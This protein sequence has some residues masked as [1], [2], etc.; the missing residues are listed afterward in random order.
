MNEDETLMTQ[1]RGGP[2]RI[3]TG[4]FGEPLCESLRLGVLCV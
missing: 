4:L 1:S 2:Q 3:I